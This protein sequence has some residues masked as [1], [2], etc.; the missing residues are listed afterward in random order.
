LTETIFMKGKVFVDTNVLIY[1]FSKTEP[2]KRERC[3]QLIS[4]L[5]QENQLVW[6]TQVMQEFCHVL[7]KKFK[8]PPEIVKEQLNLF[9]SFE[10][11]KNDRKILETALDFQAMYNCSYWDSLIL[12]AA[13]SAQCKHLLSEDM[14]TG[15]R[16][17]GLKIQSPFENI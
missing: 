4:S 15:Q 1:L 13:T 17:I 3:A 9:D 8:F 11:V 6:S 2:E 12:S 14:Q 5:D 16:F 7:I 10:L